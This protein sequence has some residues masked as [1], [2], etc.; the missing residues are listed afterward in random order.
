[1]DTIWT[2]AAR[3]NKTES[4]LLRQLMAKLTIEGQNPEALFITCADSRI[5]PSTITGTGPGD[6]FTMRNIGNL[7]P[8]YDDSLGNATAPSDLEPS[9]GA[10]LA[11]A[12]EVLRIPSIIVCGHSECGAMKAVASG[13]TEEA[14][15]HLQVW[16]THAA[17][18]ARKL[19]AGLAPDP[20]LPRHDQLAQINA[21]QQAENLCAYPVVA[22]ALRENRVRIHAWYFDMAKTEVQAYDP[23]QHKF[24]R[25][26]EKEDTASEPP[27]VPAVVSAEGPV[28]TLLN[29]DLP[30]LNLSAP[31]KGEDR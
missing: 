27:S 28:A 23:Q 24:L 10:A 25:L 26:E 22:R 4:H 14:D 17:E 1:M 15:L 7:V 18:A 31:L 6:L 8:A 12:I 16:L 20:T 30:P 11:Y 19:T 21:I 9:M 2:G 5:V 29:Y 13:N 3:F